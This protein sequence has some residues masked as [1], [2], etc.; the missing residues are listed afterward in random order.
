[1]KKVGFV[2]MLGMVLAG[3]VLGGAGPAHAST[4]VSAGLRGGG[5][6]P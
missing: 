5:L 1:M 2:A 3:T 6:T 4:L